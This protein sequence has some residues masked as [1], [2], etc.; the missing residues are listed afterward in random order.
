MQINVPLLPYFRYLVLTLF[1]VLFIWRIA[2]DYLDRARIQ[3]YFST[4]NQHVISIEWQPF[5]FWWE[6][7]SDRFYLA[8]IRDEKGLQKRLL[9]RTSL[10]G[11]VFIQEP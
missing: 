3:T 7:T 9:C 1:L 2:D 4:Q 8:E 6:K 10:F 11:G 5:A